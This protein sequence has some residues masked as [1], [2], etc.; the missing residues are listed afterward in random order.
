MGLDMFLFVQKNGVELT[1]EN[2]FSDEVELEEVG[3]WRKA[4]MVHNFFCSRGKELDSQTLYILSRE[5]LVELLKICHDILDEKVEPEKALPT[6][7]GF[8]FGSTE[9]GEMYYEHIK[10]T[11]I[12]L[13]DVLLV[14]TAS[15]DAK[16]FIYYASW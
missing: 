11:I 13:S 1:A 4:N 8:F 10:D 16:E 2:I 6:Q 7:G 5:H 9:Y 15:K 14:N 3:Y 12:T